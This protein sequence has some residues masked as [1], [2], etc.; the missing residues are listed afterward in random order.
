MD[1]TVATIQSQKSW[2]CHR[3]VTS[4]VLYGVQKP[5]T[6]QSK[7]GDSPTANQSMAVLDRQA[8][9]WLATS[10]RQPLGKREKADMIGPLPHQGLVL[11]LVLGSTGHFTNPV[12]I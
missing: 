9:V 2:A 7:Q 3:C 10:L 4:V 6:T 12:S 8:G 11:G 1:V 5:T